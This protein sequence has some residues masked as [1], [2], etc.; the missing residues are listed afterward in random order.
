MAEHYKC[1][2]CDNQIS[3]E[4]I[5][6]AGGQVKVLCPVCQTL[7]EP[8]NLG[9]KIISPMEISPTMSSEVIG[10]ILGDAIK[11]HEDAVPYFSDDDIEHIAEEI[12]DTI[13]DIQDSGGN[14]DPF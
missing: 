13:K 3:P 2:C 12:K 1:T 9:I 4:N 6:M 8:E 10:K 14:Y 11:E 7:I 5:V